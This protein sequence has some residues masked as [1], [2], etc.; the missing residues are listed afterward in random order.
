MPANSKHRPFLC[1][2]LAVAFV[3]VVCPYKVQLCLVGRLVRYQ[4]YLLTLFEPKL[5]REF[6]EVLACRGKTLPAVPHENVI[7]FP[8]HLFMNV[9]YVF[10]VFCRSINILRHFMVAVH[11]QHLFSERVELSQHFPYSLF[12]ICEVPC[13]EQNLRFSRFFLNASYGFLAAVQVRECE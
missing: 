2:K 4:Y 6:L 9:N 12:K 13:A 5:C 1:N 10:H 11:K 3:A 7:P 8:I